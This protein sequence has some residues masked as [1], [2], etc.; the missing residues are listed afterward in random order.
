M[1]K[2]VVDETTLIILT[3]VVFPGGGCG[4]GEIVVWLFLM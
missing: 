4:D 2:K 1:R 3:H